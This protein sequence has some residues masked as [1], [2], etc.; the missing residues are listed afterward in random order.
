MNAQALG[1]C[2]NRMTAMMDSVHVSLVAVLLVGVPAPFWL[3]PY[4]V[5]FG[6][7]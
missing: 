5:S 3:G 4:C 7:V 1:L 6:T 2:D